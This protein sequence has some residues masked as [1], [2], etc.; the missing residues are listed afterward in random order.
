MDPQSEQELHNLQRELEG[1]FNV[2]VS[3][4]LELFDDL[5][6]IADEGDRMKKGCAISTFA[7]SGVGVAAGLA[8]I[9]GLAAFTPLAAAGG[10]AAGV[11]IGTDIFQCTKDNELRNEVRRLLERDAEQ[12]DELNRVY[13]IITGT[14]LVVR[15]LS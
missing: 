1:A 14:E 11:V 8:S 6:K 10:V 13:Q 2:F 3:N 5:E 9:A 12:I 7:G 4:R 15:L